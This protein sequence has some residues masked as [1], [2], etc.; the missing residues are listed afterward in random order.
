MIVQFVFK[1]D[2][3]RLVLPKNYNSTLQ[4]FFYRHMDRDLANFL[5]S[6]GFYLGKRTFK[7]FV[8]S[9]IFGKF[10]GKDGEKV[11]YAP[12]FRIY[13]ASP[14]NDIAI[15]TLREFILSK[16]KM[17]L[18]ENPVDIL[19]INPVMVEG[20]NDSLRVKTVSPITVYKTPPGE[21]F[22]RYLSPHDE[23]FYRLLVDN[24]RRKYT[25]VYGK[26]PEGDIEIKPVKVSEKDFKKIVFKGKL[27]KA[28][29][30]IFEIKA[31]REVI[32]LAL[33]SGL[34]AKNSAGFGMV[35]PVGL[36]V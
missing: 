19:A 10:L 7:L 1:T 32:K 30:G 34:G 27:I 2:S 28:W 26:P 21:R 13:F 6:R 3:E 16:K 20:F 25:L 17:V 18:G 31:P 36:K 22:H 14:R 24:I 35:L 11:Y 8:F 9:K 5:H 29:N 33:E 15:G 12:R 23:E 4:G